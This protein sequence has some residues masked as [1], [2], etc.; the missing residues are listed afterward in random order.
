MV[1]ELMAKDVVG[2]RGD[3]RSHYLVLPNLPAVVTFYAEG[4]VDLEDEDDEDEDDEKDAAFRP[5]PS[6]KKDT[7]K[8]AQPA[9]ARESGE[10]QRLQ[11]A[12]NRKQV[13]LQRCNLIHVE[14]GG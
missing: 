5:P 8:K 6:K 13:W 2:T 3:A 10:A 14:F 12:R 11:P 1:A 4:V 9:A 7:G